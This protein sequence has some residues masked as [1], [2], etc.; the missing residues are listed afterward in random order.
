LSH[1]VSIQTRAHDPVAVRA[2][3]ERLSL[4]TPVQ[5]E[6][7]LFSGNVSGWLVQLNGWKYPA[8]IDTLTGQVKFDN[9]N[10]HWGEQ[11]RL[12]EF[13]K[14]YAAEKVKLEARKKG[15]TVTEQALTDGGIK[16]QIIA[17]GA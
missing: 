2:A 5:G 7:K 10:G 1:I 4:P 9:F 8:V 14:T 6:T 17:G 15:Y 3:C 11:S 16:L 13:L 12:D